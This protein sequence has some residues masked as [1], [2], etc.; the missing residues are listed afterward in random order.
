VGDPGSGVRDA[1]H[2]PADAE[3]GRTVRVE[4]H[5]V[6]DEHEYRVEI[7]AD[8]SISP[9]SLMGNAASTMERML[10]EAQS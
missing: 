9:R 10:N 6:L 3:G 5:L 4:L 8:R 2:H 7:E 1:E